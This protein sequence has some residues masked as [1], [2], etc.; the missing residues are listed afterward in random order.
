M[1]DVY[2]MSTYGVQDPFADG[3]PNFDLYWL[4][5]DKIGGFRVE[6]SLPLR[7]DEGRIWASNCIECF[8][9]NCDEGH[10]ELEGIPRAETTDCGAWLE[11]YSLI[12]E[13]EELLPGQKF[14][15]SIPTGATLFLVLSPIRS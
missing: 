4:S 1:N 11:M 14:R 9:Q 7:N 2:Q 3:L 5:G 6:G 12:Y 10:Y 15:D 13:G 8:V